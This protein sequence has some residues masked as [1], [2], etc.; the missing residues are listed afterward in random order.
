MGEPP[1]K[2]ENLRSY[3]RWPPRMIEYLREFLNLETANQEIES[4]VLCSRY[5]ECTSA[6]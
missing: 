6:F 1:K 2:I 5:R 4:A 3:S